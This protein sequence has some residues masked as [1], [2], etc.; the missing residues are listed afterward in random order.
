MPT[1]VSLYSASFSQAGSSSPSVTLAGGKSTVS[2]TW[3]RITTGS[4]QLSSSGLPDFSDVSGSFQAGTG[5]GLFLSY[6]TSGSS[7]FTGS[8]ELF[9]SGS[10][11]GS[12]FL[13]TYK[14]IS[15][16]QLIDQFPGNIILNVGL[17][18]F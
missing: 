10:N 8:I 11:T 2:A 1:Y 5:S 16:G 9:K 6:Y 12:L 4:Y 13:R 14:D 7:F 17:R 15:S 3:L 18:Y